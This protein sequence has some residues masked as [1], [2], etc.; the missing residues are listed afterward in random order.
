VDTLVRFLLAGGIV[1][2]IATVVGTGRAAEPD[3]GTAQFTTEITE[4]LAKL[5]IKAST[6][7]T[8]AEK[9]TR[10]RQAIKHADFGA[11]HQI[12]ADVLDAST[13][14]PW[15]FYPFGA[16]MTAISD[17]QDRSFEHH[18]D[19]WV[20]HAPNDPFP[21]LTRA[22]FYFDIGWSRRGR[23][24]VRNTPASQIDSFTD[25]IAKALTDINAAI[26][27]DR[28]N[29]YSYRLKLSILSAHGFSEEMRVGFEEAIAAY[30]DF[31]TLYHVVLDSL[32]PKW[33]GSTKAMYRFVDY[34]AGRAP[35]N[36]PLKLLYLGLYSNLL[37]N[38]FNSCNNGNQDSEVLARCI[39][40]HMKRDV[41]PQLEEKIQA[42]LQLYD[43]FE[44]Q[45]FAFIIRTMV[46]SML[47]VLGGDAYSGA[48]LERAATAT[49]SSIEMAGTQPSHNDYVIDELAAVPWRHKLLLDNSI[50]KFKEALRD[51]EFINFANQ[52]DKNEEIAYVYD[53]LAMYSDLKSQYLT[54][55]RLLGGL[56]DTY[57]DMIVYET[58]A[59]MLTKGTQNEHLAC[60]GYYNLKMYEEAIRSC[61]AV[62][63]SNENILAHYWRGI[64]YKDTQQ[65][66]AA[67][68]DL[69]AVAESDN[70]QHTT[71]AIQMVYIYEN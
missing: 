57:I 53:Q 48:I 5:N 36:S 29:P 37:D 38:A 28:T 25:Y 66:E 1:I 55:M 32:T 62:L 15:R 39:A 23:G 40:I 21:Q 13:M 68:R 4:K 42:V 17:V 16:L 14:R 61:T 19:E 20:A 18:L 71:A 43:H 8:P 63:G 6:G 46:G 54:R 70:S 45:E 44:H 58:A 22:K 3:P 26:A 7:E 31:F 67:L 65:P 60:Y 11:A 24:V 56:N 69:A 12:I 59:L 47:P 51:V 52:G 35:E 27:L 50:E 64:A 33:G 34:Y 10:A 30:P 41:T 49:H 2:G 9:A